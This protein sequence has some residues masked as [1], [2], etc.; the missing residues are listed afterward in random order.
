M[1]PKKKQ[2]PKS[3]LINVGKKGHHDITVLAKLLGVS[4]G[5]LVN[6][7]VGAYQILRTLNADAQ[8]ERPRK[9]TR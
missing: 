6:K 4:N 8:V 7:A 9:E 5:R 1:E 3:Y 2:Q